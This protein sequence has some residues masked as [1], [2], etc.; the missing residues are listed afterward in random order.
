MN[1]RNNSLACAS[2]AQSQARGRSPTIRKYLGMPK[3]HSNLSLPRCQ[4][5]NRSNPETTVQ[6]HFTLVPLRTDILYSSVGMKARTELQSLTFPP[7][8]DY[9][10]VSP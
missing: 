3:H 7:R 10:G 2:Y 6:I 4:S 1:I 5:E 8:L 9:S